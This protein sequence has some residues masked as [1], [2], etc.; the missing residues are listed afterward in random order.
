M[1]LSCGWWIEPLRDAVEVPSAT[2]RAALSSGGDPR[3]GSRTHALACATSSRSSGHRVRAAPSPEESLGR[4]AKA[5]G[6]I[7]RPR[8]GST[9]KTPP[10][11]SSGP[12][13]RRTH[14]RDARRSQV[15]EVRRNPGATTSERSMRRSQS[16]AVHMP[17]R[18]SLILPGIRPELKSRARD[19]GSPKVRKTTLCHAADSRI[20]ACSF[21]SCAYKACFD[22]IPA[23]S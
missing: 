10:R 12:A 4:S 11:M 15:T 9:E 3:P 13:I 1:R 7:H 21:R 14:R 23:G 6:S 5:Q 8:I 16:A 18:S 19:R 17:C 22:S 20:R 2:A